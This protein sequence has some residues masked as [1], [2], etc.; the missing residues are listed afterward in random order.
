MTGP[1]QVTAPLQG[2][3]TWS[4]LGRLTAGFGMSQPALLG[5]WQQTN[6]RPDKRQPGCPAAEVLLDTAGQEVLAQIS[7]V[8]GHVLARALPSFSRGPAAFGSD[9][10]PGGAARPGRGG[11]A[12]G[13]RPRWLP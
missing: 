7:G 11:H 9:Q 2:E 13:W 3:T 12:G 4:Y 1:W 6:A 5:W 10:L 8:P